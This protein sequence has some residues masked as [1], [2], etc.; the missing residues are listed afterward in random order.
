M[1][2]Y[3]PRY[4]YN[5]RKY[6]LES[7]FSNEWNIFYVYLYPSLEYE[8]WVLDIVSDP[9]NKPFWKKPGPNNELYLNELA[10]VPTVHMGGWYDSYARTTID[11]FEA[12]SKAKK[13]PQ[14]LI[15]GPWL[16]GT[17]EVSFAILLH[18]R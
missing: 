6:L 4:Y 2:K 9:D 8:N 12:T 7:L 1:S 16:H 14:Y 5:K 3:I 13:S 11:Q 15:M 17:T 10:D 18:Y